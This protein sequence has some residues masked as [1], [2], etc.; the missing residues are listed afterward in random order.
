MELWKKIN[1]F[2]NYLIS[3]TGKVKSFKN[4]NKPRILKFSISNCGYQQ[5]HLSTGNKVTT[6]SVHRLVIEAFLGHSTLDVNHIDGCKTN[7]ELENLEYVTKSQNMKH[8]VDGGFFNPNTDGIALKRRK[9]V[10]M[11]DCNTNEII[12]IFN[13]A[14]EAARQTGWNRG[15]ISTAC[16]KGLMVCGY[17]W[18]YV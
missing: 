11:I 9:P 7:N 12:F 14:H 5:V 2:P 6:K 13:S 16:R 3:N 4:G 1:D 18:E 10:A 8:A 17:R 15:N